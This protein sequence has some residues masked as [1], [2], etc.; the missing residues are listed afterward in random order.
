MRHFLIHSLG[1]Q[2]RCDSRRRMMEWTVLS[3]ALIKLVNIIH[4]QWLNPIKD[5]FYKIIIMCMKNDALTKYFSS[6]SLSLP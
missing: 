6:L 4:R 3:H 2:E 1:L 5:I